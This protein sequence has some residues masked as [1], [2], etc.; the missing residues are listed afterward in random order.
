M[1]LCSLISGRLDWVETSLTDPTSH[2]AVHSLH[3]L[4]ETSKEY[5]LA[6][7]ANTEDGS[8]GLVWSSCTVINNRQSGALSL[9]QISPDTVL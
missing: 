3:Q 1:S 7:A 8:S 6:V 5:Q 4:T 9:V 2:L